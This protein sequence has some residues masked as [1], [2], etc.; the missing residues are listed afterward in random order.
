MISRAVAAIG[1]TKISLHI[2]CYCSL[3][4]GLVGNVSLYMYPTQYLWVSSVFLGLGYGAVQPAII[5]F[6]AQE[7]SVTSRDFGFIFFVSS[8]STIANSWV[9][10]SFIEQ[11][12]LV[13][14]HASL[15]GILLQT[16]TVVFL[17]SFIIIH[18]K[19]VEK[20]EIKQNLETNYCSI[21]TPKS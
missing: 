2:I 12:P 11:L 10:G 19:S 9:V 13:F 16:I 17:H 8:T 6:I 21:R 15:G 1:A 18:R 20:R 5:A 14:V 4:I 7:V 3:V